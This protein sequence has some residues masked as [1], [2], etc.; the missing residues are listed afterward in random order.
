MRGIIKGDVD[1]FVIPNEKYKREMAKVTKYFSDYFNSIC[2]VSLSKLR[3]P[4]IID[5]KKAGIDLDKFL[6]IDAITKSVNPDAK[7]DGNFVGVSS[8]GALTEMSIVIDKVLK[9]G[10]FDGFIFDSLSTLS[11]YNN[12]PEMMRF[13]HSLVNKLKK[14]KITGAFIVPGGE[15]KGNLMKGIGSY[16]DRVVE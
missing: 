7:L 15:V 3:D 14:K 11:I 4:L 6:I 1:V 5:L 10:D 8:P 2:Y 16:V 12:G 9:K 13:V